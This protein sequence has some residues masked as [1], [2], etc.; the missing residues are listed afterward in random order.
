MIPLVWHYLKAFF[1]DENAGKRGLASLAGF[2]A[3]AAG[4]VM[5][6]GLPAILAWSRKELLQHSVA[7]L[8]SA[9]IATIPAPAIARPVKAPDATP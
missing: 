8:V 9:V 4:T 5:A 2:A 6:F 3:G 7:A 1:F